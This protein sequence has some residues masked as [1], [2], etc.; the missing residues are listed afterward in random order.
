VEETVNPQ[1]QS[2]RFL[3]VGVDAGA[4]ECAD[5]GDDAILA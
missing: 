1:E 5:V 3:D 4:N 2:V